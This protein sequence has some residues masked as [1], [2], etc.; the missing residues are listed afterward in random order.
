MIL[1]QKIFVYALLATAEIVAVLGDIALY[2]WAREKGHIG[3]LLASYLGWILSVT[4][5]GWYLR[6]SD[7]SFSFAVIIATLFMI[8]LIMAW[9]L[10]VNQTRFN[11]MQWSGIGLGIVAIVLY[12]WGKQVG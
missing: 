1:P 11:A 3:W 10:L 9:D 4:L 7:D 2:R 5:F 6:K 12:E 8:A